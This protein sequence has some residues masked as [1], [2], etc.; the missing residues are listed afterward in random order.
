MRNL[1]F[2]LFEKIHHLAGKFFWLDK[3]SIFL[4]RDFLY[5]LFPLGLFYLFF[6]YQKKI[7]KF[8]P[9]LFSL[10]FSRLL[11]VEIIRFFYYRARPF[12]E[13][14][15]QPLISHSLSSSFPSGHLAFFF[16]LALFIY[17]ANKK[18]GLLYILFGFL[19][20]LARIFVG[21][22][23]PTDIFVGALLGFFSALIFKK[24]KF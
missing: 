20:G 6:A 18:L 17:F 22:H 1:D 5:L 9:L 16:P 24:L 12:L 21:V 13:F 23:Y 2:F 4:A 10:I 11:V 3:I 7:K 14:N 19:I 15:F 8:L